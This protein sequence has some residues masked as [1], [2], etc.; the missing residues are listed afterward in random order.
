MYFEKKGCNGIYVLIESHCK[1][2]KAKQG[3]QKMNRPINYRT[4]SLKELLETYSFENGRINKE[5]AEATKT[6]IVNEIYARIKDTFDWLDDD[7]DVE[8]V[9]K[10]LIKH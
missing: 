7:A 5:D 2:N 1:Q 3:G 9:Y 8:S 4:K 6:Y 10:Q